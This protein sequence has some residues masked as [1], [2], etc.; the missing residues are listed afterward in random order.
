MKKFI[1]KYIIFIFPLIVLLICD[2]FSPIDAF[3]YRPWEA[4]LFQS[5]AS[6]VFYPNQKLKTQSVGDLC[7]HT[8]F[9]I[10]KNE[11]W[12]TD[13][14]GYRNNEFIENA[15]VLLIGDSFV[16]GSSIT[17]DST[18]TNLLQNSLNAPVYNLAPADFINFIDLLN[19]G[20]IKKPK[21]VIYSFVE[22]SIPNTL[23]KSTEKKNTEDVSSI[24]VFKD[25]V[26]RLYSL[27]YL[28]SRVSGKQGKGVPGKLD[29]RMFFFNGIKQKYHFDRLVEITKTIQ[30]YKEY[31]DSIG[32]DFICLPLPNKETVYFDKVPFKTQPNYLFKLD[33]ILKENNI[34]TINT[35]ELF[36]NYRLTNTKLI[37]HLDD[38]HWNDMGVELV[39]NKLTEYISMNM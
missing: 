5:N 8:K 26:N 24:S 25:K 1:Y 2:I 35:L 12:M 14:L 21:T 30:S 13:K 36:N 27:K 22:R 6:M 18:I 10:K 11:I 34:K 37:Y 38:T 23:R 7:H 17:Q 15:D 39:A 31:C 9:E 20:I 3:T 29:L 16:V 19:Q 4:L 28:K 32:V 33:S